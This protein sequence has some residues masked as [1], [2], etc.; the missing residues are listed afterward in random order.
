MAFR[1]DLIMEND[2]VNVNKLPEGVSF[3]EESIGHVSVQILEIKTLKASVMLGKPIGKYITAMLPNLGKN[4]LT[5]EK[6][7][8][9]LSEYIKD[10]IP[11]KG[12]VLVVGLGN[13]DITADALG[14]KTTDKI[15]ATRHLSENSEENP[16]GFRSVAVLSAGVLG[17]TGIE[18]AEII[19]S[20][21]DK[22]K[23]SAIIAIDALAAASVSRLGCTLQIT[24]AGIA[25][26]SGVQNKR[27]EI[28]YETMHIPVVALGIPTVVDSEVIVNEY[29]K[30]EEE[31][32]GETFMVSPR[33]IDLV[34]K[35][36]S[37]LL[38][39]IIN[40]ALQENLKAKDIEYLMA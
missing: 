22:I 28:S 36:G 3:K 39:M 2:K 16:E 19:K 12:T 15:I 24:N 4:I 34:I 18:S 31:K 20:V 5:E 25:P 27:K 14:I 30:A 10:M 9:F 23:P 29:G 17:Q 38:S 7:N 8:V 33:D 6:E 11:Q 21:S 40:L 13:R 35:R 37:G 1:T 26:G 32:K